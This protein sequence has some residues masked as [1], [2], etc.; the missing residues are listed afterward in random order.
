MFSR[1]RVA[2]VGAGL[3]VGLLGGV[4]LGQDVV[5]MRIAATAKVSSSTAGTARHPKGVEVQANG[6]IEQADGT[7]PP[8]PRSFDVWLPKGWRFNGAKYRT[9]T[10][11]KLNRGGPSKCPPASIVGRAP[12]GVDDPDLLTPP[13]RVT[14][15]NGGPTKL[16]FWIVLQ[17][18][19]RVAAA[20]VGTLTKL[21]APRW[22][23]RLH[24]E[25]PTSLDVVAGIPISL[26]TFR[27]QLGR[28]DWIATT[29]CPRDHRWRYR[30]QATY[31]SGQAVATD[32]AIACRS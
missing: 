11:A 15:V 19:A 27:A 12:L 22:S 23:A 18:P 4:A 2:T 25:V 28:G 29:A 21:D 3:A 6:T 16:Y 20:A 24:V 5:P 32:G 13:P 17:N 7:A 1:K 30:V 9:C 14:V 31:A 8:M 26:Q 10:L